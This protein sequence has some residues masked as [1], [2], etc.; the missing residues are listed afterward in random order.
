[1]VIPVAIR[2]AYSIISPSAWIGALTGELGK[3][4]EDR[5]RSSLHDL[6]LKIEKTSNE[7]VPIEYGNLRAS[8]YVEVPGEGKMTW[9]VGYAANYAIYVH[10]NL[11]Q[12]LKG[13]KRKSGVGV[14]WGP[15]GRPKFLES[16]FNE[17]VAKSKI[18][19]HMKQLFAGGGLTMDFGAI[20]SKGRVLKK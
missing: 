7:R 14:Y 19:E 17:E 6:A 12:K 9:T 16:A 13:Q 3:P 10:E 15:H 20:D 2:I 8:S 1:M 18:S 4:V 11:E 5:M